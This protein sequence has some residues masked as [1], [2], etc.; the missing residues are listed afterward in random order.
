MFKMFDETEVDK[1]ILG[2]IRAS[3][4]LTIIMSFLSVSSVWTILPAVILVLD[5]VYQNN[6]KLNRLLE[7]QGLPRE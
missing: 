4:F 6:V 3:F 2:T 7:A 1:Y 5:Y